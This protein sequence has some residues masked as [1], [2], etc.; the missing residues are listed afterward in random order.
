M[1]GLTDLNQQ[2]HYNLKISRR[3]GAG[4]GGRRRGGERRREGSPGAIEVGAH[5]FVRQLWGLRKWN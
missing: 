5:S 3:R 1:Q 4:R 2:H